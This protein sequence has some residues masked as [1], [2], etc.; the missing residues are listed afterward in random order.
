MLE[1]ESTYLIENDELIKLLNKDP[2]LKE[3]IK[4][5]LDKSVDYL[6][7]IEFIEEI[8]KE[9]NRKINEKKLDSL[10][11]DFENIYE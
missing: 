3:L 6:D 5:F 9:R 4:M 11:K 8:I 10:K 7:I 1:Y 2:E